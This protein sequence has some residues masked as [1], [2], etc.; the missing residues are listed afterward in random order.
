MSGAI[1]AVRLNSVVSA[2]G[3]EK[4][5]DTTVTLESWFERRQ[6]PV[7]LVQVVM[8]EETRDPGRTGDAF[9]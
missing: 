1:P 3:H 4:L 6:E 7:P 5:P 2:Q 9:G 8:V